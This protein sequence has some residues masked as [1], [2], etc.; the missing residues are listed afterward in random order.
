MLMVLLQVRLQPGFQLVF[1]RVCGR[2]Q[3][4]VIT[5]FGMA[6]A[7]LPLQ[8]S[9]EG[10]TSAVSGGGVGGV[11]GGIICGIVSGWRNGLG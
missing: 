5:V 2:F 10:T 8:P 7:S 4:L 1:Q 11:T 3:E 9:A 6:M